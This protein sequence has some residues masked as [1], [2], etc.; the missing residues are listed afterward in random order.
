MTGF[1]DLDVWKRSHELTLEIYRHAKSF[2]S[3]ERFRFTD[4]L[5]RAASSVPTNIAEGTGRGGN[6]EFRHFLYVARGSVEEVKYLLLLGRDLGYLSSDDYGHL[7]QGYDAVGRM[8]NGLIN[9]LNNPKGS[10][11]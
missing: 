7:R 9:S 2:P 3:N 4:Q 5:C 6:R 1:Q 11:D 8:L 10:H